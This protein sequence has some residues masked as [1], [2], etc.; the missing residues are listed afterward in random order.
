M[1][2]ASVGPSRAL[3]TGVLV[4]TACVQRVEGPHGI[5][6]ARVADG[7]FYVVPVDGGVVV[8][9][10]GEQPDGAQLRATI[11]GRPVLAILVTHAHHDHYSSA[12]TFGE[13]PCHVGPADIDRMQGKTQHQGAAQRERR[14]RTGGTDLLPPLP[15]QLVPAPDGARVFVGGETFAAVAL[16]GHTPGSTA[17]LFRDVLF[18]GDAAM[19]APAGIAPIDARFSDEPAAAEAAVSRLEAV[20]FTW[21]ADGHVG[22]GRVR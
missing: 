19:Q 4:L 15:L 18:G 3:L 1:S 16:P 14:E 22:L 7:F 13:V 17:W 6:G 2:T 11:A 21:L 8:V 20:P 9:D 5:E 10:T 12:H